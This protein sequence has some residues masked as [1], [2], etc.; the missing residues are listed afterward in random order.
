M[1]RKLKQKRESRV[2]EKYLLLKEKFEKGCSFSDKTFNDFID[3]EIK[4][5]AIQRRKRSGLN[6]VPL[7]EETTS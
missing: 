4:Y 2:E 5:N 3:L 1:F 6:V 7:N